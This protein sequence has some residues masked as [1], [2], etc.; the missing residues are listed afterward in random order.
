MSIQRPAPSWILIRVF[1]SYRRMKAR[2]S[3]NTGKRP[4]PAS[5]EEKRHG[6]SPDPRRVGATDGRYS[7]AQEVGGG[8]TA[9]KGQPDAIPS[10]AIMDHRDGS[11][12]PYSHLFGASTA[13]HRV[14]PS[15]QIAAPRSQPAGDD[16]VH[17][18]GEPAEFERL[19]GENPDD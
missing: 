18:A 1:A 5:N 2:P 9:T 14:L 7:S 16:N 6:E 10:G 19:A 8:T 13:G 15:A 11:G 17:A 4:Y 12:S 3:R